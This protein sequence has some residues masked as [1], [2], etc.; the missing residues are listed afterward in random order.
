MAGDL[1]DYTKYVTPQLLVAEKDR[2]F[3]TK[4]EMATKK[5]KC[6]TDEVEV[7]MTLD[8]PPLGQKTG[9]ILIVATTDGAGG[10]VKVQTRQSD[11][12]VTVWDGLNVEA[13]APLVLPLP[14]FVPTQD[15]G[16]GVNPSVRIYQSG[17]CAEVLALMVV[18]YD[19]EE[20]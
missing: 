11:A 8:K 4:A 12:W 3:G 14:C 6:L 18:Y 10:Q 20:V 1:P 17:S 5:T 19:E 7:D 13:S 9:L 2:P 16:D 15:V